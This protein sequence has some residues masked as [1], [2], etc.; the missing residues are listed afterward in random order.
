MAYAIHTLLTTRLDNVLHCTVD[1]ASL[2]TPSFPIRRHRLRNSRGVEP[3]EE[4]LFPQEPPQASMS[5]RWDPKSIFPH[6][7]HGADQGTRERPATLFG[8]PRGTDNIR[9]Q[10]QRQA[11]K[12]THKMS[13]MAKVL[14]LEEECI[15][16]GQLIAAT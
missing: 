10:T 2:Q 3:P 14:P 15:A 11:D 7:P 4:F 5:L 12:L 9:Q 13:R 1:L 6:S 16:Q 8:S